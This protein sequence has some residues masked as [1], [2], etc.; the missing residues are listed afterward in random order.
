MG[1]PLDTIDRLRRWRLPF[2]LVARYLFDVA[3]DY[4]GADRVRCRDGW[5]ALVFTVAPADR[6]KLQKGNGR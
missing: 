4:V 5:R 1:T 2:I 6:R 3:V